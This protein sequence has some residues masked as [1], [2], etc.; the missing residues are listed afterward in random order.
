MESLERSKQCREALLNMQ[1][2]AE[3]IAAEMGRTESIGILSMTEKGGMT[4]NDRKH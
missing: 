2:S 4:E 3:V 1:K